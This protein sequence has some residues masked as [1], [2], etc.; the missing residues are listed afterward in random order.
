MERENNNKQPQKR[1]FANMDPDKQREIAAMGG[2]E[3]HARGTAHQFDS[4]EAREAG[5]KGGQANSANRGGTNSSNRGGTSS[6][7]S[8]IFESEWRA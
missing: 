8:S 1:G 4:A 6:G 5:R 2:R 3:A 7:R